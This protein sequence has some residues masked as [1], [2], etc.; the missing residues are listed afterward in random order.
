MNALNPISLEITFFQKKQLQKNIIIAVK[1][2]AMFSELECVFKFM[3]QLMKIVKFDSEVFRAS[4]G[5]GW[6]SPT[7]LYV[8]ER[9]GI[10]YKTENSSAA[11]FI[12][13][14]F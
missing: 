7:E 12:F 2:I 5:L 8:G 14:D 4:V 1:K 3:G 9:C 13:S 10:A 11:S 6:T